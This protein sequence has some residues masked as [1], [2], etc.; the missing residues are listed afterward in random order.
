MITVRFKGLRP[1][2]PRQRDAFTKAADHWN[3][4]ITSRPGAVR[5]EYADGATERIT[6]LLIDAALEAIDGPG[7]ALTSAGPTSIRTGGPHRNIPATGI[8]RFDTADMAALERNGTLEGVIRH[9]MGHVLGFGTLFGHHG[10]VDLSHPNNPV[11]LGAHAIREYAALAGHDAAKPVPLANTGGEG[12]HSAHWRESLFGDELMTGFVDDVMPLSRMSIAAFEDIGYEA[13][14]SPLC[15]RLRITKRPASRGDTA[16]VQV[17]Y[18]Q[19]DD[20]TPPTV[21]ELLELGV[22]AAV[23]EEKMA[24]LHVARPMPVGVAADETCEE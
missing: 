15:T 20:F 6:G 22:F 7:R 14:P 8:M 9:E 2:P 13:R 4:V 19:A 17:D 5:V 11:F 23:T 24:H 10:L 21:H 3:K 18:E 12:T 16:R 1:F